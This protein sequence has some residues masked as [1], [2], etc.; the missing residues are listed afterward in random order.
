M[1]FAHGVETDSHWINRA[2]SPRPRDRASHSENSAIALARLAPRPVWQ[3]GRAGRV[4]GDALPINSAR[5]G[6]ARRERDSGLNVH[7]FNA[8]KAIYQGARG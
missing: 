1:K 7:T 5:T 2:N 3:S 4:S 6:F 8:G